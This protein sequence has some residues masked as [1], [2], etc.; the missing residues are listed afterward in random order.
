MFSESTARERGRGSH[1]A[2]VS[3]WR[4]LCLLGVASERRREGEPASPPGEAAGTDCLSVGGN[5]EPGR[6]WEGGERGE[7]RRQR[8]LA[9]GESGGRGNNCCSHSIRMS[10]EGE[11]ST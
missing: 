10:A 2:A 7:G 11:W 6:W 3:G 4:Q 8:Y 1:G 9:V 5:D